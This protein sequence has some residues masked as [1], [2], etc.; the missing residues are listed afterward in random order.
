MKSTLAGNILSVN[1]GLRTLPDHLSGMLCGLSEDG[2]GA[3]PGTKKARET[4]PRF[5]VFR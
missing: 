1:G 4:I 3:A 2:A 5:L